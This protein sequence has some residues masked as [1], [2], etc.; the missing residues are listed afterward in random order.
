[1]W[2]LTSQRERERE[3][4]GEREAHQRSREFSVISEKGFFN[5]IRQEG[6]FL[7]RAAL[8]QNRPSGEV[9]LDRLSQVNAS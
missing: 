5:T 1:M 3:G 8:R 7:R 2:S 9:G 4:E 6:T